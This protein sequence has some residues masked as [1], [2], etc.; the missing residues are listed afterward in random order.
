MHFNIIKIFMI[1]ALSI[2]SLLH[3]NIAIAETEWKI[4]ELTHKDDV[5]KIPYRITNGAVTKIEA[6]PDFGSVLVHIKRTDPSRYA[7]LEITVPREFTTGLPLSE[8]LILLLNGEEIESFEEISNSSCFRTLSIRLPAVDSSEE[9]ELLEIIG[10]NVGMMPIIEKISP[11]Y[12]TTDR[13]DYQQG[14][15]VT[16]SGCTSLGLQDKEVVVEILNPESE[17]Y[18]SL[19]VAPAIDGSF[20]TT[21]IVEGERGINGTYAVKATYASQSSSSHFVVPEFPLFGIIIFAIAISF[22]LLTRISAE[23]R[24]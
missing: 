19:S 23:L 22:I 17:V 10:A 3:N 15:V 2:A 11:V 12:V 16:I 6:D 18:K 1:I 14:E 5:F 4:Y 21:I 8:S 24:V 7:S 13:N 9:L 20:S